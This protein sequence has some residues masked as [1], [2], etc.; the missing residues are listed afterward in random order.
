MQQPLTFVLNEMVWHMNQHADRFLKQRHAMSFRWFLLLATL[1]AIEPSSQ[2]YLAECLSYSDAAVSKLLS[3]MAE[4]GLIKVTDDPTHA[5]KRVVSLTE[6]GRTEVVAA[7][8]MLEAEFTKLL[9]DQNIDL[10]SFGTTATIIHKLLTQA[11]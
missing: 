9:A 10:E 4:S 2:H 6:H 7:T 8:A 1:S 5:R 3:R 11:P